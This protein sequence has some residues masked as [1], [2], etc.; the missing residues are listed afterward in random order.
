[1]HEPAI[2]DTEVARHTERFRQAA[3]ALADAAAALMALDPTPNTYN[4]LE[5]CRVVDPVLPGEE[6]FDIQRISVRV[7][8]LRAEYVEAALSLVALDKRDVR[9][10]AWSRPIG[11]PALPAGQSLMDYLLS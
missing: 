9:P 8:A 10:E 11:H 3:K 1:M 4:R 5:R 6:L 2:P 7:R